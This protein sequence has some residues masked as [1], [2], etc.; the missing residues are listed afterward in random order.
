MRYTFLLALCLEMALAK[1]TKYTQRLNLA[2]TS[3][4]HGYY[5]PDDYS[6]YSATGYGYIPE[7]YSTV[8]YQENTPTQ[9]FVIVGFIVLIVCCVLVCFC[10]GKGGSSV[11]SYS[12]DVGHVENDGGWGWD[13][14]DG[15]D[16]GDGGG[17]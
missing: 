3:T 1:V 15:G 11:G 9:T 4:Y 7:S 6:G 12:S 14:D 13:G 2:S 16:G 10:T 17:D 8:T 5:N